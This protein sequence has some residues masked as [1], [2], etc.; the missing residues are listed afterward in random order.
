[1]RAKDYYEA[2]RKE[3]TVWVAWEIDLNSE[4]VLGLATGD[5]PVRT[6]QEFVRVYGQW[7]VDFSRII[8]ISLDESGGLL[9]VIHT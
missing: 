7:Q 6:Y 8:T 4:L 3:T 1:M 2:I 9:Q 5:S